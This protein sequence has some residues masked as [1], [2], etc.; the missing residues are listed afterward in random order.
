[1]IKT[2]F[3]YDKPREAPT[4]EGYYFANKDGFWKGFKYNMPYVL[5]NK[6]PK[7]QTKKADV[8]TGEDQKGE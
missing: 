1:M 7:P 4:F 6:R 8:E 3:I 5:D 2:A